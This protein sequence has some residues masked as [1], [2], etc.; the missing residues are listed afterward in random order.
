MWISELNT[1]TVLASTVG[2]KGPENSVKP[3]EESVNEAGLENAKEDVSANV[4]RKPAANKEKSTDK[5]EV[6]NSVP[7]GRR[8]VGIYQ[9]Q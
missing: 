4:E 1:E 9:S 3:I 2:A 7:P 6:P 5:L 8:E